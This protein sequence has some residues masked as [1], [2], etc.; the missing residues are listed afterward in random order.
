MDQG[1]LRRRDV[2]LLRRMGRNLGTLDELR[3]SLCYVVLSEIRQRSRVLSEQQPRNQGIFPSGQ[4]GD[5]E[6]SWPTLSGCP[7]GGS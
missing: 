5:P 3:W 6:G 2:W 4:S 7:Q 1:H